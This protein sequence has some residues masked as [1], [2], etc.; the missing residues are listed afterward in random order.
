MLTPTTCWKSVP[1]FRLYVAT[2]PR[3]GK[4]WAIADTENRTARVSTASVLCR[5]MLFKALNGG[6]SL[7]ALFRAESSYS[8]VA[9]YAMVLPVVES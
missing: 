9:R 3:P 8:G 4:A 7:S 6:L 2:M 5:R 1:S